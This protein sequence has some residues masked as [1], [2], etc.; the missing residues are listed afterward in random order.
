ME[1]R[2]TQP[3]PSSPSETGGKDGNHRVVEVRQRIP[4]SGRYTYIRRAQQ[5]LTG[6][7]QLELLR[8][9][10]NASRFMRFLMEDL[11]FNR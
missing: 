8:S 9:V 2:G 3:E 11:H 4:G 10:F 6:K 5:R 7:E 1:T